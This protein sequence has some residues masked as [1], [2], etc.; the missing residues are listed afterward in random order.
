MMMKDIL[1][2]YLVHICGAENVAENVP[3]SQ[4]TTFRIGGNARYFVTVP[5]ANALFR[6]LSALN[7]LEQKYF[8]IGLGANILADSSGYNGVI[9]KLGFNKITHNDEFIYADAG[10][11]LGVVA[12]YARENGLSGLEWCVGIPATIGGA[13]F[14]NC[15]AFGKSMEDVVAMVDVIYDGEIKTL[16]NKE[17]AYSYRHSIFQ[18]RPMII[19]GAYLKMTKG[20][21][22]QIGAAMKEILIKRSNHP[23]EPSAGS[24][25]LRPYDGFYV[26]KEIEKLGLKGHTVGGAK[27]S[28]EHANFIINNGGATSDDVLNLIDEIKTKVKSATGVEL[29]HEIKLLN[30]DNYL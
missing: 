11:K 27:V 9:I 3:L 10:A 18:D 26:G 30:N 2:N 25:F 7:F 24:V 20:D 29:R 6:L 1:L 16:T 21:P 23:K 5:T 22:E 12:N 19:I 8:I 15:G 28:D 14:M 13:C 4:K 17:I